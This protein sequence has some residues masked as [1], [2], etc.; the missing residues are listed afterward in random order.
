MSGFDSVHRPKKW[1]DLV[2]NEATISSLQGELKRENKKQAYL[3]TGPTGI[4]KTT[5]ARL[6]SSY[7]LSKDKKPVE[8]KKCPDY[9]EINVGD[10][11]GVDFIRELA[12]NTRF[13]PSISPYRIF[14][15]DEVQALSTQA[16]NALL[17][18]L[19]EPPAHTIFILCS[20]E[21]DAI[22]NALKTRCMHFQLE[23]P[24]EDLVAERLKKIAKKENIEWV[25][26]KVA[27]KI[28]LASGKSIR[29]AV[30]I[31]E[32]LSLNENINSKKAEKIDK[33]ISKV[34]DHSS[35]SNDK[36]CANILAAIYHG[37]PNDAY[38][39]SCNLTTSELSSV[40]QLLYQ[41]KYLIDRVLIPKHPKTAHWGMN[42]TLA[43][44]VGKV[45][46]DD[47]IL[48]QKSLV[49]LRQHFASAAVPVGVLLP[50][51]AYELA[52]YFRDKK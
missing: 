30:T 9:T 4:G 1:E 46:L 35:D 12:E 22:H 11:S 6:F 19:E 14:V 15:L 8:V 24:E 27:K 44:S 37:Q 16:R 48:V 13:R 49:I 23:L 39:H 20:M 36:I 42:K 47:V 43:N 41:N 7:L 33:Y 10:N 21:G 3:F 52:Q 29:R 45:D 32:E 25:S 38:E 18:V 50:T 26:S 40:L 31:L 34:I 28:A 2:G 5:I 51:K 17:K